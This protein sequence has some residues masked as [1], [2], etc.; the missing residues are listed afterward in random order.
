MLAPKNTVPNSLG[1]RSP[2][3][4]RTTP[5]SEEQP[6]PVDTGDGG[7]RR[8]ADLSRLVTNTMGGGHGALV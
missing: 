6:A 3:R 5:T 1:S 7:D 2:R 8:L 4:P